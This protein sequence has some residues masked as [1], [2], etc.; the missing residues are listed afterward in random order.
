MRAEVVAIGTEL[1]LGQITD[2]NSSWIGEQLALVGHR[3]VLPDQGGRQPGPHRR[4]PGA[5]PR[6]QRRRHLLR[7]PGPHPGRPH[8]G[9]HRRGH[10]RA[11][12]VRRGD[13]GPDP[14]TCSPAGAGACRRTTS[15]RPTAGGG[16]LHRADAG[17]GAGAGLPGQPPR[18]RRRPGGEGHLR[19]ARRAVGDEGDGPRARS[20]PTCERRAGIT[21]VIRSRTLRTWGESESGLAETLAE[22]IFELDATGNPTIAFL[23]SGME[24]LKV[25]ITAKAATA[26]EADALLAEEEATPPGTARPARVRR[27]RRHDGVRGAR[28]AAGTGLDPG[29]R[30]VA[31]RAAWSAP[32]S[33]TCPGRATS[34]GVAWCP[35]R[36]R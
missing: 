24:G 22:R 11:A 10:G 15:A 17:H 33:V 31:H 12:R 4:D 27:G 34:S 35:T 28:H 3:L 32:A 8:P 7:G 13:G 36:R 19:R 1:L 2:T 14:R 21:A 20:C 23:A 18:C 26:A 25:R 30:R 29:H 6:A 5:R 16:A 9:G